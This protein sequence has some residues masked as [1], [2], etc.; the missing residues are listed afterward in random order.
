MVEVCAGAGKWEMDANGKLR[1][2][3]VGEVSEWGG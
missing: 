3:G 2:L 1:G